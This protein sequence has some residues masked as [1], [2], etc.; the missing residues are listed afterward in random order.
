MPAITY[1]LQRLLLVQVSRSWARLSELML[2]YIIQCLNSQTQPKQWFIFYGGKE[3]QSVRNP[4]QMI[5]LHSWHLFSFQGPKENLH[6]WWFQTKNDRIWG[7]R[8]L[9]H[10][11]CF[12]FGGGILFQSY[13]DDISNVILFN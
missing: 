12:F 3:T 7:L 2:I 1:R 4:V 5:H 13:L 10:H 9:G 8:H 11:P 6:E